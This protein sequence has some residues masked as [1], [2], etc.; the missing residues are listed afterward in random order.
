MKAL[1]SI[2]FTVDGLDD[3]D[4]LLLA[5]KAAEGIRN[6]LY[7]AEAD[8]PE[9]VTVEDIETIL[10]FYG[11]TIALKQSLREET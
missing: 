7:V 5:N 2:C 4:L 9:G 6:G 3:D 1:V 11:A 8:L 10:E